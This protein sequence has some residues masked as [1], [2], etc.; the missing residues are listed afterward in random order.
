MSRITDL[1]RTITQDRKITADEWGTLEPELANVPQRA[2]EEARE[3]IQAFANSSF[4][5]ESGA[6][7]AMRKYLQGVGYEV[8]SKR[9]EAVEDA[10][11]ASS[12]TASNIAEES[13]DFTALAERA[14]RTAG[15]MTIAV[16]DGGFDTSHVAFENK[17]WR[18]EGEVEGDGQDNDGNGMVDDVFGWDFVDKDADLS[19]GD[20]GTHVTGIATRGTDRVNSISLRVFKGVTGENVSNAIDYAVSNGARVINMSFKVTDENVAAVV[21]A[22]KRHPGTLFVASAGNDGRDLHSYDAATYL[23][24]HQLPNF[25]VISASDPDGARADYTNYGAPFS[26]HAMRGSDVMSS[27]SGGGYEQMDGTSMAAPNVTSVAARMLLLDP[28]LTPEQLKGM[29]DEVS[30]ADARWEGAVVSGGLV[31]EPAALR[32]AALTGLIRDGAKPE[33]AAARLQLTDAERDRLLPLA[34]AYV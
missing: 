6:S 32:L 27:V 12:I 3:V 29:M 5:V 10:A 24:V 18:N 15:E 9:P 2:S 16:L 11:Y 13:H 31:E 23:K 28:A 33:D 20:H 8:P 25:A 34:A 26:T 17:L 21:E 19:S 30:T 7:T 22:I 4:E 14:G 1:L